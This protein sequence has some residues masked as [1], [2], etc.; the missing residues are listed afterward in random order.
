MPEE[1][2]RTDAHWRAP[3][4]VE[5]SCGVCLFIVLG[6]QHEPESAVDETL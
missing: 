1:D 3:A 2:R 4:P 5:N 6:E